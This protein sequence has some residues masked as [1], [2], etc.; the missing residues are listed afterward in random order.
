MKNWKPIETPVE[1]NVGLSRVTMRHFFLNLQS[2]LKRKELGKGV[3][4]ELAYSGTLVDQD[5]YTLI[6]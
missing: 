2:C 3:K 4:L 6:V 1:K 5:A